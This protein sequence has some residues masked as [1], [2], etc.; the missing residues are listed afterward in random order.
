[1]VGRA[2]DG[3]ASCAAAIRVADG[4]II[5]V[6]CVGLK[7]VGVEGVFMIVSGEKKLSV[8]VRMVN[9]KLVVV[10]VDALVRGSVFFGA[11]MILSFLV[12][13]YGDVDVLELLWGYDVCV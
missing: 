4:L 3:G 1:M 6:K 12:Y 7:Y 13:V 10:D 8:L 11:A 5:G 2:R 9:G